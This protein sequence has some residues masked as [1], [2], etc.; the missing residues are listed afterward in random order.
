MKAGCAGG[1]SSEDISCAW[2][3]IQ[4]GVKVLLDEKRNLYTVYAG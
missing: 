2:L 4:Q 3:G 1:N